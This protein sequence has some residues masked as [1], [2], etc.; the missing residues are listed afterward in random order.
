[1]QQS[2]T[3]IKR[4]NVSVLFAFRTKLA[5]ML[6]SL[7]MVVLPDCPYRDELLYRMNSLKEDAIRQ[8]VEKRKA[9]DQA[10]TN[11]A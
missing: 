11:Q 9:K 3:T 4:V 2:T 7:G 6:L 1:M 10:Q 8:Y 5:D